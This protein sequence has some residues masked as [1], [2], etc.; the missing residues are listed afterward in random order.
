MVPKSYF[1][2]VLP[3]AFVDAGFSFTTLHWLR[4]APSKGASENAL[5]LSKPASAHADLLAFLS[6]RHAEIRPNGTLTLCIPGQGSIG[7][8]ATQSC[9]DATIRQLSATYNID[10][11]FV[12]RM[13]LY[14]RSMDEVLTA[15]LASDSGGGAW[16]GLESATVPIEHPAC[17]RPSTTM[18]GGTGVDVFEEYASAMTGFAMAAVSS[19]LLQEVRAGMG[20]RY[21]GDVEFLGKFRSAFKSEFLQV[22]CKDKV[23]FTYLYLCLRRL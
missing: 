14:L 23:G 4:H 17:P 22:Y 5:D 19:L 3:D 6:A 11:T 10:P 12:A 18:T 8:D 2:Q 7:I 21:P 15:I 20:G 16:E 9:L 1:Q 13:P